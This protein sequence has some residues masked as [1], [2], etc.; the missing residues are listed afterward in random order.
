MTQYV[1]VDVGKT[2]CVTCVMDEDDQISEMPSY[3]NT[4]FD[5]SS[6]AEHAVERYD[7][8]KGVVES[9][10]SMRLKTYE[11]PESEGIEVKLRIH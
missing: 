3:A 6:F 11:A 4:T 10:E 1:A 8:C 2:K 9:T 5:A 7:E